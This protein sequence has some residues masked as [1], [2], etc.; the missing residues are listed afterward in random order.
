MTTATRPGIPQRDLGQGRARIL[1]GLL[2]LPA[3]LWYL[4]LLV[5]PLLIV[6][7]GCRRSRGTGRKAPHAAARPHQFIPETL[8][9]VGPR[10]TMNST[11]M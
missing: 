9:P 2:L 4:V 3:G 1:T 11:A 10:M 7:I 5:A 6:L 8:I